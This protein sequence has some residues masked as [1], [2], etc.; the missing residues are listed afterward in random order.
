M[1][2]KTIT[3]KNFRSI[4]NDNFNVNNLNMIVGNNDV[5]KSNYLKALNLFF[6]GQTDPGKNFKF[7]DDYCN[8]AQHKNKKADEI[9]IEII[10][11]PPKTYMEGR[12]V[13]WKKSWRKKGFFEEEIT[14]VDGDEISGK[15]KIRAWLKHLRYKYVPAIKGSKYFSDLLLDLHNTLLITIEQELKDA[16]TGF[17]SKIRENTKSISD[18]LFSKLGLESNINLPGDLSSLFS[19]LEFQTK[20]GQNIVPLNQRGDG[21]KAR[22]IPIILEYLAVQENTITAQGTVRTSTIWGYE[23]PENNLEMTKAFELANEFLNYAEDI[24]IFLTTHSPAFYSLGDKNSKSINTY[25]INL[26]ENN[27]PSRLS[28]TGN[29]NNLDN[30][31]GILPII[32]PHIKEKLKEIKELEN[33]N[34]KYQQE[35]QQMNKPTL[36]VEG[37][38]DVKILQ[39]AIEL[40]INAVSLL[41]S[42]I[43]KSDKS[44]GCNYVKDMLIGWAHSRK[45]IKTAG[46][47]DNDE[48]SK[49]AK[50]EVDGSKKCT[51]AKQNELLKTFLL[52]KSPHIIEIYKKGITLP[53]S[54]EDLFP[55]FIFKHAVTN[56]WLEDKDLIGINN[57]ND[58]TKSF[59]DYCKEKGLTDDEFLYLKRVKIFNK[60]NFTNYVC[61]LK[62]EDAINA[63]LCFNKLIEEI[64]SFFQTQLN[65]N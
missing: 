50:K 31:M 17:I 2:I 5:G 18:N 59:N 15:T 22:H 20:N 58:R 32:T 44:A 29:D 35:I 61:G 53:F 40:N 42:I 39:K 16:G 24:Q 4:L 45:K 1:F 25:F 33:S 63:F 51:S 14:Y 3:I 7:E 54:I 56:N 21:I 52:E 8:F 27:T 48:D 57:F 43:I 12:E 6:N 9:N 62:N 34:K 60:E 28:L 13:I 38:T 23:E 47:F 36:F 65:P 41:N 64:K 10:F 26:E 49:K 19:T 46:L 30:K 55:P 11:T 37:E